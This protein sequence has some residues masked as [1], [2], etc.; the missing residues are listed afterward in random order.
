[1]SAGSFALGEEVWA[2]IDPESV[3]IVGSAQGSV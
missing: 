1:M 2:N 3:M